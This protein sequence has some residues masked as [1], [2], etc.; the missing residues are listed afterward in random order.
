MHKTYRKLLLMGII[1]VTCAL[2]GIW[3]WVPADFSNPHCRLYRN[4][5]W[6]SVDWTSQPVAATAVQH[7]AESAATRN[8]TA[9][10]PYVSYLKPDRSFSPSYDY[11]GDFV[12]TFRAFNTDTRI[13]AWIGLPLANERTIGIQGWADLS[14]PHTR[15][16]IVRFI[17]DLL[18]L[19]HFDGVH[20]NAETVQNHD[21]HFLE[22]LDEVRQ[23]IGAD[24]I[25]SIA[26][27]HWLPDAINALPIIHDFRWT[28]SYYQEVALRVDQIATMTYDSYTFA[29]AL[30]RL[31]L[32]EQ[33]KGISHSLEHSGVELLTG[34]S[35]SREQTPSHRPAVE[36]LANGLAGLCAGVTGASDIQGIAIYADWEFDPSDWRTWQDWQE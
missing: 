9:V 27:S 6:I 31:W 13:L 8:L 29:P 30:Y 14:D 24:K 25:I 16:T 33:V 1:V 23:N 22:L 36:S 5:A 2:V 11:A 3:G 28:A 12:T 15:E 4:A 35:V 18:E 19:S 20:I 17:S 34:I 32:R 26:G 10:F 21:P 7:L